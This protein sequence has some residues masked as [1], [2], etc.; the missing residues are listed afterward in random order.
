[1]GVQPQQLY[2]IARRLTA[3]GAIAKRDGSYVVLDGA[4]AAD[5]KP[6]ADG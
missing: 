5:A 1:M 3:S 2:A 4:P 6:T